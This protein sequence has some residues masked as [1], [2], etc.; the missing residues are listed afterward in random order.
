ME[1]KIVEAIAD[2]GSR[3][4]ALS[5]AAGAVPFLR[6]R[7]REDETKQ[8]QFLIAFD[9]QMYN[10]D[11]VNRWKKV[12]CMRDVDDDILDAESRGVGEPTVDEIERPVCVRMGLDKDRRPRSHGAPLANREAFFPI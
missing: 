6:D 12:G 1:E 10:W 2:E 4:G 3:A 11:A 9:K 7:L 8:A 5:E